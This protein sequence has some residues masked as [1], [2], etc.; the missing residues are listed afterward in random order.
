MKKIKNGILSFVLTCVMVLSLCIGTDFG[1]VTV[2]ATGYSNQTWYITTDDD[3]VIQSVTFNFNT[4]DTAPGTWYFYLWDRNDISGTN[5]RP[6]VLAETSITT[7]DGSHKMTINYQG[8]RGKEYLVGMVLRNSSWSRQ[9]TGSSSYSDWPYLTSVCD[10][11][12]CDDKELVGAVYVNGVIVSGS[13]SESLKTDEAP[14]VTNPITITKH[15]DPVTVNIG[16]KA[17][18][19]VTATGDNLTYQWQ[20]AYGENKEFQNADGTNPKTDTFTTYGT[21][22]DCNGY[23][24]RCI[25]TDANG[26]SVTSEAATL[27]LIGAESPTEIQGVSITKTANGYKVAGLGTAG[28]GYRWG[29]CPNKLRDGEDLDEAVTAKLS[30]HLTYGPWQYEIVNFFDESYKITTFTFPGRDP[31]SLD[32]YDYIEILKLNENGFPC[33]VAVLPLPKDAVPE[34]IYDITLDRTNYAD[35]YVDL[36]TYNSEGNNVENTQD[37][38]ATIAMPEGGKVRVFADSEFTVTAEGATISEMLNAGDEGYYYEITNIAQDTTLVV[39]KV[40]TPVVTAPIITGHP[41]NASVQEG[42]TATFNVTAT[43]EGV[44]YQWQID[45]NDGKGFVNIDGATSASYTMSTVDMD[46]NGFKYQCIVSNAGGSVT[47]NNAILTVTGISDDSGDLE[48]DA[49]VAPDAPID[50]ATLDNSKEE[51]LEAGNIFTETEKTQI[52]NGTDAR[53]WLEIS[54]TD[55]SAIASTD[56]AKI[57]Q[58]AT[59]IMG[60]NLIVTYFDADLFK[61]V[62]SGAKQEITEPGVAMKIT[63]TIPD[64]LL[65]SDKTVSREYK[66]IR[67]HEGQVDVINGTFDSTTGEFTFE[68][69]KFSTY[70]I[71]YKDVPVNANNP[72]PGTDDD[73]QKPEDNKKDEAPKTGDSNTTLYSFMFMLLS[74]LGIIICSRKEKILNKEK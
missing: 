21:D 7:S 37:N 47:S 68:S 19:S 66:I 8:E 52:A 57:E 13:V 39:N 12:D 31:E 11:V 26:N 40:T 25:I 18:F 48:K 35:G 23:Q 22:K 44:T 58:V 50:E 64:E 28:E 36:Y 20:V 63:I 32:N 34:V 74:G 55:E 24:Y 5:G 51:L 38:N 29:Y 15:P 49:D 69:D 10:M 65:N 71:V 54:K 56:K 53:V 14:V 3:G 30:E 2:M 4:T 62:G 9:D 17:T 61:Q 16:E 45:R 60:D 42:E 59:K 73:A 27:T 70:A 6:A 1:V 46:C 72:T 67:L 43:G 33:E 41:Q